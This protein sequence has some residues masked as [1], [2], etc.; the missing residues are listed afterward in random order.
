MKIWLLNELIYNFVIL[1][2]LEKA[3]NDTMDSIPTQFYCD[4]CLKLLLL[5]HLAESK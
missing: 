4:F 2:Q 3:C 5:R 1:Q